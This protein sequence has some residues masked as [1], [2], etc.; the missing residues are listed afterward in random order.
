MDVI[1]MPFL[2]S[3]PQQPASLAVPILHQHVKTIVAGRLANVCP[4]ERWFQGNVHFIEHGKFIVEA[5]YP[6]EYKYLAG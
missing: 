6:P 2:W 1:L 4:L 3:I 5:S